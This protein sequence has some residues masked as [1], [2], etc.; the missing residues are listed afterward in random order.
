MEKIIIN[1]GRQIGSGGRDIARRLAEEFGCKLYDKEILDIAAH[2]SG[3]SSKFFEQSDEH[4]GFFHHIVQQSG[5]ALAMGSFY[6]NNQF[7]EE[8]LFQF[9]SD[10]IR[11]AA[12][13]SSCVFVGRCADYVL[14]DM[15]NVVNIFVTADLEER[16]Q[17]VQERH[18][19]DK[20]A[21]RKLLQHEEN[22]RASYYNYYT[23]KKCG[24]AA[25][26]DICVNTSIL[27]IEATTKLLAN[28]IR[29][30]TPRSAEGRL[31]GKNPSPKGEGN[32]NQEVKE[33][34]S[35]GD[36]EK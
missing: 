8:S 29:S 21:A 20:A 23:G 2:E 1:V 10:A 13:E 19:C 33:S 11:K 28:F 16:L 9:Q 25:S 18:H 4:K 15:E 24:H 17:R 6:N 12:E 30:L 3:F 36:K 26:Y 22:A 34:G 31:Q 27:G 14:R 32:R 5:R 7:S 35:Q